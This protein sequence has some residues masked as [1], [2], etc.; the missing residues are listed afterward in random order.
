MT[1]RTDHYLENSC[2]D[3]EKWPFYLGIWLAYLLVYGYDPCMSDFAI[4][5]E[6]A[7]ALHSKAATVFQPRSP[8]TTKELFAGRW[9]E[10]TAVADAVNQTGLHVVIY[11]ERGVGKTSLANVL[12]PTIWALDRSGKQEG[13]VPARLVVKANASTA[14]TFTTIW[15][16][17]FKEITW[18]DNRPT[19]GLVPG[20]KKSKS[21]QEA[22]S[23]PQ[24]LNVDDVRRVIAN[25]PGAVFI[26]DE[27]DRAAA[28]SSKD[29]TDLIKALSD[30]SLNCTVIIVGVSDTVDQLISDHASINRALIQVLVPRMDVKDLRQILAN[31]EKS[32]SVKFVPDAANFIVH[33]S[34]GLPHYT[35]LIGLNAVRIAASKRYSTSIERSDVFAALKEAVKQSQQSVTNDHSTA[36]HSSHKDALYRQVLLA[37]ALTAAVSHDALGYFTPGAVVAPLSSVLS[38]AVTIATFNSHLSEFCQDKRGAVLEREGQPRAYRF[39]F[40]DPLLVP[41]IFMDAVATGLVSDEQLYQMLEET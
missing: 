7:Q 8:I 5:F 20:R 25:M 28:A 4:D 13:E 10:L 1:K 12:S 31:A 22:F 11:G 3:L 34:Q 23:L 6:Q 16:K 9:N 2:P 24:T 37:C 27:F 40:H 33:V 36:I 41:Y 30:F 17:L 21:I 15:H 39:R 19:I 32:L 18:N 35:H 29:F 26:V 14:D 38:K